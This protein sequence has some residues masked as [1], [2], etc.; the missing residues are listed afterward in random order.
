[1]LDKYI[2]IIV[3]CFFF[4]LSIVLKLDVV[5]LFFLMIDY[6]GLF[7]WFLVVS[8]VFVMIFLD[9]I[10]VRF[11]YIMGILEWINFV[12]VKRFFMMG[13]GGF[14]LYGFGWR[15]YFIVVYI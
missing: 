1:M 13:V 3:Y 14:G 6:I 4:V 2:I 11:N 12:L 7:F 8:V 15:I 5:I 9:K 10:R